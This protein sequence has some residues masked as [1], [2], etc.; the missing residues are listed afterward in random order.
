MSKY[1]KGE[2]K[3]NGRDIVVGQNI[4]QQRI[5]TLIEHREEYKAED[6]AN[7]CLIAAAPALLDACKDFIAGWLH[8]CGCI[9]FGKSFLDADAIRF[10]N[11][12]PGKIQIA[13]NK[14]EQANEPERTG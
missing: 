5:C 6:E 4:G 7:A 14:A 11:E 13:K 10:M 8:F 3:F 2:W 12:V 9:D 1:T